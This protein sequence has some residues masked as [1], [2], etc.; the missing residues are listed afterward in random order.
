PR[1]TEWKVRRSPAARA[2][3]EDVPAHRCLRRTATRP[4]AR[5]ELP[6]LGS[7]DGPPAVPARSHNLDGG[8]ITSVRLF[9]QAPAVPGVRPSGS[10]SG[11]ATLPRPA[12]RLGSLRRGNV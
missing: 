8:R 6:R 2:A 9:G 7:A 4:G 11:R 1:L 5:L 10:R 12:A 3:L